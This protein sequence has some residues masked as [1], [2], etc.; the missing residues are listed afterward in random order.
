MQ[1]DYEEQNTNKLPSLP[2]NSNVFK[3]PK[4]PL[5]TD[6]ALKAST[7]MS[8]L[9]SM[10]D[11]ED[12]LIDMTHTTSMSK[13]KLEVSMME[14]LHDDFQKEHTSLV[15]SWPANYI[16]HEYFACD[17]YQQ[18]A[19][20]M[21]RIKREASR[22]EQMIAEGPS[23]QK[24]DTAAEEGVRAKLP[25]LELPKFKGSCLEWPKFISI[26]TSHIL[27]QNQL[28]NVE[29]LCY[30]RQCLEGEPA[31]LVSGLA[32]VNESLQTSLDLLS[33]WYFNKH[34][35]IDAEFDR[36]SN[37]PGLREGNSANLID[38]TTRVTTAITN[39]KAIGVADIWDS[40]L[41]YH[42]SR[43]LDLDN[44]K[45]WMMSVGTFK[46]YPRYEQLENFIKSRARVT[47]TLELY[48]NDSNISSKPTSQ[49]A[50]VQTTIAELSTSSSSGFGGHHYCDCCQAKHF[51]MRCPKFLKLPVAD[52]LIFVADHYLCTNC[53]RRHRLDNCKSKKTCNLCNQKHHTLLHDEE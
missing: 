38:L 6:L 44:W 10:K 31:Q 2:E 27:S 49:Q 37:M 18:E 51:I 50:L 15:A 32:L 22:L 29:K 25:D 12:A 43:C 45:C 23:S 36:I 14:A 28:N 40:F 30:L 39:L 3:R 48:T 17:L 11:I 52:R 20:V 41:V 35:L 53:L 21:M 42:V 19:Q 8:R 1:D 47:R 7:Q 9:E 16:H 4:E 24:P 5:P 34:L 26:F 33:K 46:E 13:V